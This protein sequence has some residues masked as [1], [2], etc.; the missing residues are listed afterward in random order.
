MSRVHVSDRPAPLWRCA[1]VWSAVTVLAVCSAPLALHG[2]LG[3]RAVSATPDVAGSVV[4]VAAV[5]LGAAATWLWVITTHAVLD[6]LRGRAPRAGSGLVRRLVLTACGA[7]VVVGAAVGPASAAASREGVPDDRPTL[8]GLPL[9]DRTDDSAPSHRSRADDR[10]LLGS[11]EAPD[12]EQRPTRPGHGPRTSPGT[13]GTDDPR[14]TTSPEGSDTHR[15]PTPRSPGETV[16]VS[17]G[18]SLWSIAEDRLGPRAGQDEIDRA[19]RAIWRANDSSLGD[20]PDLI[21]PGQRLWVP[22]ASSPDHPRAGDAA[23]TPTPHE[24]DL[25]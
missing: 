7:A 18:D 5:A 1:L 14:T 6:L 17:P 23:N 19:W 16:R 3:L 8:S 10:H 4:D 22:P 9:P 13:A 12:E 25:S 15:V 24:G 20:D 2:L 21:H 11:P